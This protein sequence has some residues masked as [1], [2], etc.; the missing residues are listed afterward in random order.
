MFHAGCYY[1]QDASSMVVGTVA[2]HLLRGFEQPVVL[3]AAAA[4][5]GKSTH[6]LSV[7]NGRGVLVANEVVPQRN[8]VLQQNVWKWGVSNAVVTLQALGE[9]AE[10]ELFDLI[11]LDA[12]CSGEG[13]FRRDPG[14]VSEWSHAAVMG[15][16]TRQRQLVEDIFP[17]LK[18]GGHLIYSTCTY[19]P[20][21]NDGTVDMALQKLPFEQVDVL[22]PDGAV[23]TQHGWQFYPHRMRG[24]GFYISVLRKTGDGGAVANP[25]LGKFKPRVVA[26]TISEMDMWGWKNHGYVNYKLNN[27][28][29][30]VPAS[31][32]NLLSPLLNLNIKSIGTPVYE[33]FPG[34][35]VPHP[36][37]ALH[38]NF[39]AS[40]PLDVDYDTA[41][42]YLYGD[43]MPNDASVLK[44]YAAVTHNGF[45][46]GWVK[47][48]PNRFN[49]LYPHPWRIRKRRVV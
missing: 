23:P 11:V 28:T 33:T 10:P 46:L 24:E 14:A 1:V 42:S 22:L 16:G 21:E 19:A 36:A 3:D 48:A 17:A 41:L 5:G 2:E 44:G 6:L 49:N 27:V 20:V 7:L 32:E 26:E 13:L 38:A 35:T 18:V 47:A 43:V 34:R 4:P 30:A 29:S 37:L 8:S 40:Q 9:F 15:C 31:L 12:P 39:K 45:G 25:T